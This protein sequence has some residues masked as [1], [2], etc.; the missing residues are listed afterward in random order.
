[1]IKLNYIVSYL[2]ILIIALCRVLPHPW[3]ITPVGALG[4]FSGAYINRKWAWFVPV[5]ALLI[6]DAI[7]GFYSP[8]IMISVY[9]SFAASA[10]IG[11]LLLNKKRNI[12][13]IGSTIL[14]CSLVFFIFSNT[15]SWWV[16]YPHTVDG[17]M[18]CYVNGLPYLARDLLANSFYCTI[19]FGA[20]EYFQYWSQNAH[21]RVDW[22]EKIA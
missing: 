7:M 14:I 17:L 6:G 20:Y 18:L 8:I 3:G 21:N 22:P 9:I 16:F 11:K 2:F 5:I 12:T 13:R 19:L 4:M 1:M 15:S 10:L